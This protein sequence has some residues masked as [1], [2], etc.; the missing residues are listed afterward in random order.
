MTWLTAALKYRK[1]LGIVA[2]A[3]AAIVAAWWVYD[4]IYD[5]GYAAALAAVR[6]QNER[7]EITADE[8]V[9][10]VSVCFDKGGEW[11]IET[12]SCNTSD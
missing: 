4:T 7:A 8:A 6:A 9:D 10:G 2:G 3:I 11:K 1:Q 5:R 12:G